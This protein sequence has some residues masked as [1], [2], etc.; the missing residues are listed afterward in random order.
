MQDMPLELQSIFR[1]VILSGSKHYRTVYEINPILESVKSCIRSVVQASGG[2]LLR[3]KI[4]WSSHRGFI[5]ST[6]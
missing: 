2:I 4:I 1:M 3:K 6:S 5:I